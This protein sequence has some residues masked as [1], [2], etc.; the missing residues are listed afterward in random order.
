[1]DKGSTGSVWILFNG[2]AHSYLKST[3]YCNYTKFRIKNS[4]HPNTRTPIYSDTQLPDHI[5]FHFIIVFIFEAQL[6]NHTS[7]LMML[8]NA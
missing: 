7:V 3:Q 5:G 4:Y 1:M 6:K 2:G 8:C